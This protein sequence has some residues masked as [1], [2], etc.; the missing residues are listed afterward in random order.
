M[1]AKGAAPAVHP[2]HLPGAVYRNTM[3][4]KV[5]LE[6]R[7]P[8]AHRPTE[9]NATSTVPGEHPIRLVDLQDHLPPTGFP[10][11]EHV[12][13]HGAVQSRQKR[14][15]PSR[16]YCVKT[17]DCTGVT[18]CRKTPSVLCDSVLA[19]QQPSFH[20]EETAR[21]TDRPVN[22]APVSTWSGSWKA[23][24]DEFAPYAFRSDRALHPEVWNQL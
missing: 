5:A 17:R 10:G 2:P 24:S 23:D 7:W 11:P 8:S 6:S 16:T 19:D 12:P 4:C 20:A 14:P 18:A 1:S 3:S 9:R 21:A 15:D 13:P 22:H